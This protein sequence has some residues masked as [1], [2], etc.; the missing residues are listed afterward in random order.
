MAIYWGRKDGSRHAD[1]YLASSEQPMGADE[2]FLAAD[3]GYLA[4]MG[5]LSVPAQA[6]DGV[7]KRLLNCEPVHDRTARAAYT[8]HDRAEVGYVWLDGADGADG[9]VAYSKP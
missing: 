9:V 5:F 4:A 8:G 7:G 6:A 2:G 1:V 3:T